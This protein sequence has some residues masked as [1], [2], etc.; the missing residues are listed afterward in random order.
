MVSSLVGGA[1]W[2]SSGRHTPDLWLA[3]YWWNLLHTFQLMEVPGTPQVLSSPQMKSILGYSFQV[4]A[5]DL[6]ESLNLN[7]GQWRVVEDDL[8][9]CRSVPCQNPAQAL[10]CSNG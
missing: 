10:H 8:E 5:P 4:E 6:S 7:T 9:V 1:V 3:S 2:V